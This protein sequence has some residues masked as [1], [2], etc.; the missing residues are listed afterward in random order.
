MLKRLLHRAALK[1]E[2]IADQLF[3]RT[4]KGR[5]IDAYI[6]YATPDQII[7]RGRVLSRLRHASAVEGQTRLR[8]LRQMMGMFL[9]DEV[10][11]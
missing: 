2:R 8:N 4:G 5:E 1:A 11:D 10:R 7:L 9:T 6:D 3:S